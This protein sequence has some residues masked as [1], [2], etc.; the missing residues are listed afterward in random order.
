MI[1][2]LPNVLAK[3]PLLSMWSLL[4][5]ILV[6]CA[7]LQEGASAG[8]DTIGDRLIVALVEDPKLS[9]EVR[10]A[11][12][13]RNF[14]Y[15]S[16]K[17]LG[18]LGLVMLSFNRPAELTPKQ[19]I[20]ALE[21]AVPGTTVG[22]NHAYRLEQSGTGTTDSR[23]YANAALN[24]TMGACRAAA[25]VG[26]IDTAVD[27][28]APALGR[29]RVV[30]QRFAP[31]TPVSPRHGTN[32]ASILADAS[33]L[34]GVTIFSADVM[35]DDAG[36]GVAAG[37]ETLIRALDWFAENGVRVVNMSLSGPYNKLLDVAVTAADRRGMI[38]VAAVGNAGPRVPAQYPAGFPSVIA[39]TAVDANQR[40]Y[41][42]AV[43]GG[44]V[45]LAAPGVDIFV[46]GAAGGSFVTGTS[47][48]APLVS[49][50]IIA[51]RGL[52]SARNAQGILPVLAQQTIDLGPKGADTSF[53]AGLIQGPAGC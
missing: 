31:G 1:L 20:D 5:F 6:G 9:A 22:V 16:E 18:A 29:A 10:Q 40:I 33:R 45:D 36:F 14:T 8:S 17:R 37:A 24:W 12:A 2:S 38:L 28:N 25:P 49:A 44:H 15:L 21:E 48:A 46:P 50:R 43:R 30:A 4:A 42:R 53:G 7:T 41:R 19:A 3:G 32:V 13:E 52:L 35:S 27:P 26:L 47:M 51:D 39:V 34:Q 11:A 23:N